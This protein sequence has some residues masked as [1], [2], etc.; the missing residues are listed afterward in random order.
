LRKIQ[1]EHV[2]IYEA[3]RSQNIAAA[4]KA[5]RRHLSNSLSRYQE[6]SSRAARLAE[7][8]RLSEAG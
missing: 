6:I 3:I 8:A 7:A 2:A 4:R 5:A 1:A